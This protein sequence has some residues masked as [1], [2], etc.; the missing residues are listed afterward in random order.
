MEILTSFAENLSEMIDEHR[1]T[2]EEFAK[3]VDI[4]F[5]EIYSYLR[6]ECMPK[7]STVIKIADTYGY[8]IDFLLGLIPFPENATFR[9]TPPFRERFKIL[10]K[11]KEVTRYYLHK[12]TGISMN[13]LDNWYNGKYIPALENALLL[14]K[15]FQCSLDNLFG[16]E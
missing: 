13:S 5:S 6:K 8:S 2:T 4:S 16:R 10:L 1:L 3:S 11:D 15:H 7:L 14:A 9:K 12:V